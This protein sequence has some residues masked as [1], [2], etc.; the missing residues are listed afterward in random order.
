MVSTFVASNGNSSTVTESPLYAI[1]SVQLTLDEADS[2]GA[3]KNEDG[4]SVLYFPYADSLRPSRHGSLE[5]E[6][7]VNIWKGGV[8]YERTVTPPNLPELPRFLSM[9]V[10]SCAEKIAAGSLRWLALVE[11]ILSACGNRGEI[12]MVLPSRD[13]ENG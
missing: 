13:A 10:L 7:S 12:F 4:V 1:C 3:L 11:R 2:G 8:I 5:I 9:Q 6:E